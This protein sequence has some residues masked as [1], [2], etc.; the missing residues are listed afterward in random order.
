MLNNSESTVLRTYDPLNMCHRSCER[1]Y[2]NWYERIDLALCKRACNNNRQ[3]KAPEKSDDQS[4]QYGKTR[5]HLNE[6]N[7]DDLDSGMNPF[8][9]RG[10]LWDWYMKQDGEVSNS[11]ILGA[12]SPSDSSEATIQHTFG[13]CLKGCENLPMPFSGFCHA[14]YL[15]TNPYG[16]QPHS[17]ISEKLAT[18]ANNLLVESEQLSS[19]AD[20]LELMGI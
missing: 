15:V 13:D 11:A 20:S 1:D 8:Q 2:S 19:M 17:Q 12:R 16:S 10:S 9:L 7:L 14:G 3:Y 6:S 5:A 4:T 18:I